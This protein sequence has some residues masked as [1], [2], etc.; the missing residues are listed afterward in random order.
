MKNKVL[1]AFVVAIVTSG[2]IA[3]V[4]SYAATNPLVV[5]EVEE[6]VSKDD[7]EEELVEEPSTTT[8]SEEPLIED[9][10]SS[11][12]VITEPETTES[13]EVEE[14]KESTTEKPTES[15]SSTEDSTETT[16]ST[17]EKPTKETDSSK[18]E[19]PVEK[20]EPKKE[21]SSKGPKES[22]PTEQVTEVVA[23]QEVAENF[24]VTSDIQ[25][26][27]NQSTEEFIESIGDKARETGQEY[28]LY[29][30]VMIAQAILE[31]GSGSSEL[32]QAPN[33][34]L[35]GI[36]GSYKGQSVRFSTSED[37]GKGSLYTIQASFRK[38]PGY[39]ESFED[40][41]SLLTDKEKGNGQ[42]YEGTLKKNAKTYQEATKTLT[43]RYAT[44]TNYDKKLNKLIE[45]YDLTF[46]DE[47]LENAGKIQNVYHEVKQGDTLESILA[48][49]NLTKEAFLEM[50]KELKE[51]SVKLQNRKRVVV[52]QK[53]VSSYRI[54]NAKTK[55]I[56]EFIIPLKPEYT[57]TSPFGSRGNEHH[58]GI[59]LA[60]A[61]NSAVY[62]SSKGKVA[63]KGF[64]SSAGNYVIIQHENGL[65]TSYFHLNRSTVSL[66]QEV[67]MGEMIGFV[68][69]TGNSTGPHLHFAIN[70]EL[71]SGYMNPSNYLAF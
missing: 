30:S 58:N 71:W 48:Q 14:T 66:N 4:V 70:T 50:N 25:F 38:Y 57:V 55:Q 26:I 35:F 3:P 45:T 44:D 47:K 43:G 54:R 6:V 52:G 9:T 37:N 8:E 1:T 56:G 18:E 64:D 21:E 7:A 5:D 49:N 51:D 29:A 2:L 22:V 11:E 10:T 12:E 67:E 31:T 60:I 24:N 16:T 62:A 28:G 63:A 13:T 27:K 53:K 68:G 15:T 34:N 61:A 59:D 23:P 42:F 65:Y 17:T 40:Y 20:E 33:H 69:S 19:K 39:K 46:F 36:K 41:A 32:S